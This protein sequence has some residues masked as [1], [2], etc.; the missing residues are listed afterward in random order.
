MQNQRLIVLGGVF[1]GTSNGSW[2]HWNARAHFVNPA[3]PQ[4]G[5]RG[6]DVGEVGSWLEVLPGRQLLQLHIPPH[7][8]RDWKLQGASARDWCTHTDRESSIKATYSHT[9]F[10]ARLQVGRAEELQRLDVT[11]LIIEGCPPKLLHTRAQ[12][13]KLSYQW[14]AQLPPPKK[15]IL[16]CLPYFAFSG[17]FLSV[18]TLF[19]MAFLEKQVWSS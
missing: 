10:E 5:F 4:L 8:I 2:Q 7:V 17:S 12:K 3:C 11:G 15:K 6:V 16:P 9:S 13:I 18:Y 19:L 1:S 14:A